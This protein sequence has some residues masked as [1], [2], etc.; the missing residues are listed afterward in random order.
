MAELEARSASNQ[1]LRRLLGQT[2]TAEFA[3]L[4]VPQ[5]RARIKF[6]E[7]TWDRFI[8]SSLRLVQATENE[9]EK[10]DHEDLMEAGERTYIQLLERIETRIAEINE[11]INQQRNEEANEQAREQ[12]DLQQ[13]AQAPVNE[14]FNNRDEIRSEIDE[15]EENELPD[16]HLREMLN[17]HHDD[18][19]DNYDNSSEYDGTVC[20]TKTN[21]SACAS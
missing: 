12:H 5:L 18:H 16:N 1:Q 4:N 14:Q 20:H 17:Q 2:E 11:L 9:V 21:S 3:D 19:D 7:N 13:N 6:A 8:A 15:H 10:K